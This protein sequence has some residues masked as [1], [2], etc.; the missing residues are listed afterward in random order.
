MDA[1][2]PEIGFA[3]TGHPRPGAS[4]LSALTSGD[5]EHG[6]ARSAILHPQI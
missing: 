5:A 3:R 1:A 2:F 6:R 4:A